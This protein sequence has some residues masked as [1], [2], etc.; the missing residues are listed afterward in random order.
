MELGGRPLTKS[1]IESIVSSVSV[2]QVDSTHYPNWTNL[3]SSLC[4]SNIRTL[5][6]IN[7][8]L[9]NVTERGTPYH[10]NMYAEA[11]VNNFAVKKSGEVWTGYGDSI[12]VDLTN[13]DAV[14]WFKDIIKQVR[15]RQTCFL[16][17]YQWQYVLR[18]CCHMVWMVGCVTLVSH[19][20][21]LLI[22][23][24]V[25]MDTLCIPYTHTSGGN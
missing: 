24:L 23:H 10:R 11:L 21:W 7:P 3:V 4:S 17:L 6:Y 22:W 5:T 25:K 12:L 19:C 15:N 13:P 8:L 14:A 16:Y 18:K 20:H 2:E 9:S 1:I